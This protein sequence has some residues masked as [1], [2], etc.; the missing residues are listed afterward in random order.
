MRKRP[1]PTEPS[2]VYIAPSAYGGSFK[3]GKADRPFSRL[4][5]LGIRRFDLSRVI[6]LRAASSPKAFR[7]ETNVKH[8]FQDRSPPPEPNPLNPRQGR[9]DEW[10][11]VSLLPQLDACLDGCRKEVAF[12]RIDDYYKQ[13]AALA[14]T[15]GIEGLR[16]EATATSSAII[17]DRDNAAELARLLGELFAVSFRITVLTHA[18][19]ELA[20][21][22]CQSV[23]RSE[24]RQRLREIKD[25]LLNVAWSKVADRAVLRIHDLAESEKEVRLHVQLAFALAPTS[26]PKTEATRAIRDIYARSITI[27]RELAGSW[28][29]PAICV[30]DA[31]GIRPRKPARH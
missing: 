14:P 26:P 11:D 23:A 9:N 13:M 29:Q 28:E 3:V 22:Q 30:M 18:D 27:V 4:N 1:S 31:L 17:N 20:E 7:L 16:Y 25:A 5:D 6:C 8:Y 2:F 19:G 10:F 24:A 21:V 15:G 12:V